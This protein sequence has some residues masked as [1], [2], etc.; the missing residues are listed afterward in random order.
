M[1]SLFMCLILILSDVVIV[2]FYFRCEHSKSSG[3]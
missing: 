3:G 1:S 2:F